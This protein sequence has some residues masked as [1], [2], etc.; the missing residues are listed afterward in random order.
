MNSC[1]TVELIRDISLR[2]IAL[3]IIRIEYIRAI[4]TITK[5]L[6]AT[7]YILL[8][9]LYV[10]VPPGLTDQPVCNVI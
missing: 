10:D 9:D 5:P 6:K 7:T 1:K 8:N 4:V 3:L 2:V